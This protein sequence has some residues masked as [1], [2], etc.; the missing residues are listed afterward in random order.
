MQPRKHLR[1]R[2]IST[3]EHHQKKSDIS[4]FRHVTQTKRKLWEWLAPRQK[5]YLDLRF[6]IMLRDNTVSSLYATL[7]NGVVNGKI[8]CPL[9]ESIFLELMK[10]EDVGSR[11]R[12]A[13]LMDELSMGVAIEHQFNRMEYEITDLF[14][15][16]E[17]LKSNPVPRQQLI[18][19]KAAYV[20]GETHPSETGFDAN[21][22]LAIQKSFFGHMWSISLLEM[23]EQFDDVKFAD[24]NRSQIAKNIDTGKFSHAHE[25]ISFSKAYQTEARGLAEFTA[26]YGL[27]AIKDPAQLKGENDELL[28]MCTN[29]IYQILVKNAASTDLKTLHI[30]TCLHA[31]H[32][33]NRDQQFKGND[34]FDFDHAVA[35]LGY[36]DV[37]LTERPLKA[38][39][40]QRH[41][42]L[43]NNFDCK[44]ISDADEANEYLKSII[45][46]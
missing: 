42:K 37:F 28:R 5:I 9:S 32:R 2:Q 17:R 39:L 45:L 46:T 24:L 22:E 20:F 7:K 1:G 33:W 41:H 8:I 38:M 14:T 16:S 12:S 34:L 27:N 18:W 44:V 6:W 4:L 35:A 11:R 15:K 25:L 40:E 26:I 23:I 21:I 29:L 19:T 36:C 43:M 13:E 10:Q 3:F 31:S 30:L